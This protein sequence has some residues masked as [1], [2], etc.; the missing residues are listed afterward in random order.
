MNGTL[1]PITFRAW[2]LIPT[3]QGTKVIVENNQKGW[4]CQLHHR[5]RPQRM[6]AY[7]VDWLERLSKRVLQ[8]D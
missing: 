5:L 8:N 6:V 4:L 7:H 1:K 2:Q 3:E